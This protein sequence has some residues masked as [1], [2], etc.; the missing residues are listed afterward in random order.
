MGFDRDEAASG[1]R[2]SLG[3]KTTSADVEHALATVPPAVA[4]LRD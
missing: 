2:F 3:A 1:I 4:Q